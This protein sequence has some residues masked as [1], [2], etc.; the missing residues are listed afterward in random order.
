MFAAISV[1]GALLGG[2]AW[3]VMFL[4]RIPPDVT[5]VTEIT[6]SALG[7][8]VAF[9]T[10]HGDFD[11]KWSGVREFIAEHTGHNPYPEL[12]RLT[13]LDVSDGK[14]LDL[15]AGD[16]GMRTIAWANDDSLLAYVSGEPGELRLDNVRRRLNIHDLTTGTTKTVFRGSDWYTRSL[17][18]SPDSKSLAFVENHKKKNLTVLDVANRSAVVLASGV[19]GFHICW[20][21]DGASLFCI[22]NGL[23]IWQ[24]GVKASSANLLFR[25][26]DMKENYPYLL[27]PSPDG[28]QLGF[29]YAG[30]FHSL[31]LST[32]KVEKWFDC[33]HY[34]LTFDWGDEGICYLDAVGKENVKKARVM[35]YDPVSHS[36]KEVAVGPFADV[37]WL[38]KGV[39]IVR[40]ENTELWELSVRE[41][42]MKRI[43]PNEPQ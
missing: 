28:R 37:A 42:A 32:K 9:V 24:L 2:F 1:V 12:V 3:F 39:L 23:E 33:N 43:F 19:E 27:V 41:K 6:P 16:L 31:D 22:L 11:D 10:V 25:G 7:D 14:T 38:R 20:S 40:K 26:R 13:L 21:A 35:V 17:S 29:G 8:K 18:F 15:G 4:S 34:F 36:N 30:G 5:L